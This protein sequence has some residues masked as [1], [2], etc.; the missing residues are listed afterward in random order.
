M[1]TLSSG[2][3]Y[4]KSTIHTNAAGG[5]SDY[6]VRP[7][8]GTMKLA[9]LFQSA[10]SQARIVVLANETV[11]DEVLSAGTVTGFGEAWSGSEVSTFA[12]AA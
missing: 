11:F 2:S 12:I 3:A 5:D 1:E 8:Q 6:F 7:T 4:C 10:M 9:V